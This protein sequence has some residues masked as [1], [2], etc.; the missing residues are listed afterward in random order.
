MG[1]SK[2]RLQRKRE[3]ESLKQ[4]VKYLLLIFLV[5]YLMIKLGLPA[6]IKM[7]GFFGD[8]RSSGEPIEK[9]DELPPMIPRLLPLPEAT[10][11]AELN[12]A[13]YAEAGST[14]Q[15]YVRGISAD[16]TV[17]D[18]DGNFEFK[19]I[20]L[21][22]GENEIYVVARDD[23]GNM[24]DESKTWTV[25]VDTSTPELRIDQP[26]KDDKFFDKDSPITVS[27]M[28]EENVDL[29]VN[30]RFVMVRNDGSWET[31]VDLSEGGNEIEVRAVDEAENERSET[32]TV[33]YTP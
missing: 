12:V 17:A 15:L 9:Q 32:V 29:T 10:P 3:K 14:I 30:G 2:S 11:S 6:L 20:H 25:T 33:N 18:N 31:K 8:I 13:G 1:R 4:A 22:E 19:G 27:G 24:S 7:A 28:T 23:R 26:D 21:R 16:E 5:L